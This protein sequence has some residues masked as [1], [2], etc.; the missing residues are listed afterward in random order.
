M[1]KSQLLAEPL[2]NRELDVLELLAHGMQHKEIADKLFV[3]VETFKGH[4]KNIYR[5]LSVRKRR[6]AA[7]TDEKIGIL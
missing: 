2:T 1:Y 6:D 7:E 5:K 3:S 4:L